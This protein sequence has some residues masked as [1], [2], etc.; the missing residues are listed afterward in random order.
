MK[1]HIFAIFGPFWAFR[2]QFSKFFVRRVVDDRDDKDNRDNRNDRD[3]NND[4]RDASDDRDDRKDSDDRN[5]GDDR[6][7][8]VLLVNLG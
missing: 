3:D 1:S 6:Y 8:Q 4:E 7:S 5:D 2:A